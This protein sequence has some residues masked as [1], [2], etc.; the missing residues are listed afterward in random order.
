MLRRLKKQRGSITLLGVASIG[1]TMFA[2]GSVV[3]YGNAKIL[4]REL[5]HYALDVATVALRSE[6][7]LTINMDG[8]VVDSVTGDAL[9][10]LTYT[11]NTVDN[12]L[13]SAGM[14]LPVLAQPDKAVNLEKRLTFGNIVNNVFVALPAGVA[15]NPKGSDD[16]IEFSAVAVQLKSEAG[17]SFGLTPQGKAIYGLPE[18]VANGTDIT[19]CFCDSRYQSCLTAVPDMALYPNVPTPDPVVTLATIMG[20]ANSPDRKNYCDYGYVQ[21]QVIGDSTKSKFPSVEL[22]PQWIGKT[23]DGAIPLIDAAELTAPSSSYKVIANQQPLFVQPGDNPFPTKT[24]S[25][26]D[27]SWG[28]SSSNYYARNWDGAVYENGDITNSLEAPYYFAGWPNSGSVKVDGYFYVGRKAI[29]TAG[30]TA[31]NAPGLDLALGYDNSSAAGVQRCLSYG[32]TSTIPIDCGMDFACIMAIMMGGSS[33]ETVIDGYSQQSCI[34]FNSN[35]KTKMNFF[36]WMMSLFFGSISS[37]DTSYKQL[38]CSV[39]KMQSFNIS[40]FNWL[41]F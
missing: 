3:D 13:S 25:F 27:F 31:G 2:F 5:D 21:S 1:V 6:L 32:K 35:V 15:S 40:I 37:V 20:A 18:E 33:T 26:W 23:A 4:D 10:R 12:V 39:K 29:C 38:D 30:T 11:S 16:F 22:S 7:A 8:T 24:W 36:Q 28:D 9:D 19:D 41:P 34:N 14:S 17:S